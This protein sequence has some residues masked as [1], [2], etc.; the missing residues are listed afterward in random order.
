[1]LSLL[2]PGL[3]CLSLLVGACTKSADPAS[4]RG[5]LPEQGSVELTVRL[6]EPSTKVAAQTAANEQMIRNVQVFVFRAGSGPDAGALEVAG[7]AGFGTELDVSTGSYSG[8][9]LKC[10]TGER[11]ICAVVNDVLD[12]TAGPDAVST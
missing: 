1:M 2:G 11:E 6:G 7:S 3:A 5:D 8:L 12:R 9:T 4:G 10:S